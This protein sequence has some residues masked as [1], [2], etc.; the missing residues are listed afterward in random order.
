MR[1]TILAAVAIV[2]LAAFT[3]A[4]A[5]PIPEQIAL[6]PGF[7]PEGI[8]TGPGNSFYVGSIPTGAIYKGDLKT[9]EGDILVPAQPGRAAIGV[10]LDDHGRL[11]VAGGGTGDGFVYDSETG[12]NVAAFDFASG[13]TFVNDVVVTHDSAWFTDSRQPV[14]YRVPIG[15]DGTLGAAETLPL[16]GDLVMQ[17]GNNLN[18]IDAT[19]DGKVLVAVQTNTGK[20][21]TIDPETGV[22]EEIALASGES[23]PNGDGI[24]LDGKTLYVVQN[25]VN[26][27]AKIRLSQHLS[28]G[29]V[30]SRTGH[31]TFDIPTTAA[32]HGNTLIIVNARFGTAGEQPADYWLTAMRKP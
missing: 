8:E 28:S 22:T 6:P 12:A 18:G 25:R 14:L 30:L 24:L 11:F 15:P 27:V 7:Q 5:A 1:T 23:V 26:V 16:S 20:L 9:G 10:A 31:E 29:E 19:P 13:T 21:F 17:T 3:P 4:L 32:E 2:T